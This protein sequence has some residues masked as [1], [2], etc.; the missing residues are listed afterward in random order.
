MVVGADVLV[1]ELSP[2]EELHPKAILLICHV[3]VVSEKVD[4]TNPVMALALAP[5]N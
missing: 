1:D 4:Q 3:V 2:E 5:E